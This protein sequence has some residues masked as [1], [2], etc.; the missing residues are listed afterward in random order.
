MVTFVTFR[1]KQALSDLGILDVE[2][3]SIQRLT[4]AVGTGLSGPSLSADGSRL[5][6]T[7]TQYQRDVWRIPLGP[8]PVANG[9]SAVRIL[10][11]TWEAMWTFVTRD[12]RTLLFNSPLSG[13][14]N[15]WTMPVDAS[16]SPRQITSIPDDALAHSSLSTDGKRVAFASIAAGSCDISIQNVDGSN[17]RQLTNDDAADAWPVWSPDGEWLAYNSLRGGRQETWRI[18][19]ETSRAEK[20]VDGFFRGD[21]IGQPDG[22]GT[23]IVTSTGPGAFRLVDVE[24]RS[25][26]WEQRRSPDSL[27]MPCFSADGRLISL[28]LGRGRDRTDIVVAD[29]ATGSMR[30]LAHLPFSVLFRASWIDNGKALL[31]N[32][33]NT[34]SHIVMFDR[35]TR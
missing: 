10:D 20:I 11:G 25:I 16:E 29:A 35:F 27:S 31:V 33:D 12:G 28:P 22:S 4:M 5:I 34:T 18:S 6:A 17:L 13:S 2:D 14:R 1:R 9:R 3:G 23:W 15:L 7:A 19:V 26:V 30:V 21:W 32:R 8:D 24:Q